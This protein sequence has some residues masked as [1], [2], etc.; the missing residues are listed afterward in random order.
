MDYKFYMQTAFIWG[1]GRPPNR[2]LVRLFYL[3][4]IK[5]IKFYFYCYR[6][7]YYWSNND[8]NLI[9]KFGSN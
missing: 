7:Y 8:F 3:L 5:L 1:N 4:F 6:Y 2:I 9:M